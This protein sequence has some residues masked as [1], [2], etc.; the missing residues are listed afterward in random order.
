[1]S[2]VAAAAAKPTATDGKSTTP[3]TAVGSG[4]G[5]SDP[6]TSAASAYYDLVTHPPLFTGT[7][8]KF[9]NTTMRVRLP[10]L[11]DTIIKHNSESPAPTPR[12]PTASTATATAA[13]KPIKPLGDEKY[14]VNT[15]APR[16]RELRDAV[17]KGLPLPAPPLA[18]AASDEYKVWN[19]LYTAFGAKGWLDV[20]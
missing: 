15:I 11:I 8:F 1:M 7:D 20:S 19:E 3:A 13:S 14:F 16:L 12:G 4:A 10:S 18:A 6:T 2:A 5:K 17:V 9:A